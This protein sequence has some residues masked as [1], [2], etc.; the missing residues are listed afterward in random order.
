MNDSVTADTPLLP[1]GQSIEEQFQI[2]FLRHPEVY[3]VIVAMA[4]EAKAR[5]FEHYGLA[6]IFEVIR[7]KVFVEGRRDDEAYKLNNNLRSR[8]SRFI[9]EREPDLAGFFH[10]RGLKSE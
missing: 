2:H 10:T 8:Y 3:R 6:A 4:R 1:F 9:M 7:W 5:G